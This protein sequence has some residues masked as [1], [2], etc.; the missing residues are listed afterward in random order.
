MRMAMHTFRPR[1]TTTLARLFM[2]REVLV[3]TNGRIRYVTLSQRSQMAGAGLL[4]VLIG[5]LTIGSLG[6][7]IQD[8][9]LAG[10]EDA[11]RLAEAAY[12]DLAAGMVARA[13]GNRA[14]AARSESDAATD[15]ALAAFERRLA[16]E[17]RASESAF[18]AAA[19]RGAAL[20][21][22][23]SGLRVRLLA[24]QRSQARMAQGAQTD[25]GRL[26][27][28]AERLAAAQADAAA[29][30]AQLDES[31]QALA[32]A[33]QQ[34]DTLQASRAELSE[35]VTE[36]EQ[37]LSQVQSAHDS[38]VEQ[39]AARARDELEEAEETVALTGLDVDSLLRQAARM[40]G[41]GGPFIPAEVARARG[42]LDDAEAER[43]ERL[44]VVLRTLP[45]T[46]PLDSYQVTGKF[47]ERMDPLNGEPA[48][49]EGVDFIGPLRSPVLSTAPGRVVFA[50]R[51]GSYGRMVEID[52]GL[53]IRTRYAHLRSIAVKVGDKVEFRQ[54]IGI[55][56]NSGRSTGT[57]VHYEVLVNGKPKDPINFLKAGGNVLKG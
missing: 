18:A 42:G 10:T 19:E 7:A 9:R 56:G 26:A 40:P 1:L 55:M 8:R 28:M 3:R 54:K 17:L 25:A 35:Q 57:H 31:R 5:W 43:W 14:I 13:Q 6:F 29:L 44:R 47:G 34:R 24:A 2:P 36:L 15:R 27:E 48:I 45:L 37:R 20:A 53:G 4:L 32:A 23:A 41:Q 33:V 39:L 46:A 49:H 52:H 50:G 11:L 51:K 30:G 38:L 22:E 21:E 12:R 16:A